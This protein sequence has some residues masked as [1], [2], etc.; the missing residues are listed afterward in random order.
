[1]WQVLDFVVWTHPQAERTSAESADRA[2]LTFQATILLG[3]TAS[4][5]L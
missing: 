1:M 3:C 2:I 5:N 4:L